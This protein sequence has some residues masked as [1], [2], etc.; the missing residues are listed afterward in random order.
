MTELPLWSPPV[1]DSL[2][3]GIEATLDLAEQIKIAM[4]SDKAVSAEDIRRLKEQVQSVRHEVARQV[5]EGMNPDVAYNLPE[6]MGYKKI[7]SLGSDE[8]TSEL[9]FTIGSDTLVFKLGLLSDYEVDT[10]SGKHLIVETELSGFH[11]YQKISPHSF[12][13]FNHGERMIRE[14]F[15]DRATRKRGTREWSVQRELTPSCYFH[16]S[17]SGEVWHMTSQP[18]QLVQPVPSIHQVQI[19]Q[20][21]Q[22]DSQLVF[23]ASSIFENVI[24]KYLKKTQTLPGKGVC[25]QPNHIGATYFILTA[26][27]SELECTTQKLKSYEESWKGVMA[28]GRT[29]IKRKEDIVLRASPVIHPEVQTE[30]E[31]LMRFSNVHTRET[32]LQQLSPDRFVVWDRISVS[33]LQKT[34]QGWKKTEQ[35]ATRRGDSLVK[36]VCVLNDGKILVEMEHATEP[37]YTRIDVYDGVVK[38]N[39]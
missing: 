18:E 37:K 9:L 6:K 33:L 8:S 17:P 7:E 1:S 23:Q 24:L 4:G 29:I 15:I 3:P 11:R 31:V 26:E 32:Q 30:D 35:L 2:R 10:V 19:D 13:M 38:D 12:I 14:V 16:F 34:A 22:K 39:K 5:W 25:L 36:K 28:D 27:G 21:I 20:Y